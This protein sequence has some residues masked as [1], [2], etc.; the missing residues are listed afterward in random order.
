MVPVLLSRRFLGSFSSG[1]THSFLVFTGLCLLASPHVLERLGDRLDG[2]PLPDPRI[3]EHWRGSGSILVKTFFFSWILTACMCE[4]S[5]ARL[6]ASVLGDPLIWGRPSGAATNA[7]SL[8]L[9]IA[10]FNLLYEQTGIHS[11]PTT[12]G[13]SHSQREPTA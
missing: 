13:T 8:A 7:N 11:Q 2:R 6:G 9:S 3:V 12:M 5:H 1:Y 4:T 10:A